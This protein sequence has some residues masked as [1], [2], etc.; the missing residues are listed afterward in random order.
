MAIRVTPGTIDTPDDLPGRRRWSRRRRAA[1]AVAL[2]LLLALVALWFNRRPIADSF[3]RRALADRGVPARYKITDLSFGRQRLTDVVIGDP[4][5]PD[6]VADWAELRTRMTLRG[7]EV[8][9]VRVGRVRLRGRLVDGKVSLGTIDKLMPAPSG[10]PFALPELDAQIG[11]ARMRLETPGGVVG[12]KLTGSGRLD[13][14]FSGNLAAVSD[15]LGIGDACTAGQLRAAVAIRI[16]DARPTIAGPVRAGSLSCGDTRLAGLATRIDLTLGERLDRWQGRAELAAAEVAGA[17]AQVRGVKGRIDFTGSAR[18][19][20]GRAALESGA[21]A[22]AGIGG[23]ALAIDGRY[24][25]GAEQAFQGN[26]QMRGAAL[27]AATLRQVAGLGEAGAGSPVGPL[28]A[29]IA[30][31]GVAAGRRFDAGAE[32]D[33]TNGAKGGRVVV[34]RLS[35]QAASGAQVVLSGAEGVAYGW[36]D[37]RASLNGTLTIGG[38]GLPE[39]AVQLA[40]AQPGGAVTGT[41]IVRP[42]AAGGARLALTPVR[43]TRAGDGTTRFD[44]QATL[45]GPLADGRVDGLVVPL[46]GRWDGGAAVAVNPDCTSVAW[47][48][49]AVS[50]LVLDPA[51]LRLCPTGGALVAVNRAGLGGGARL[52]ATRLAGRLGGTPVTL[53]MRGGRLDLARLDFAL[54]GVESRLGAPERVTRIDAGRLEGRVAGGGVGGRFADAAGQIA[55]VPLLLSGAAGDWR[56]A[57]GVLTLAGGLKLDDTQTGEQRRFETMASDD[58]ALTLAGNTITATG[59]L[60]HPAKQVT[61]ATVAIT[62]E[63]GTGAG[64]A[65]LKVPGIAFG[66]TFQPE[67]LTPL[68]FGVIADVKAVVSGDGHIAWNGQGVTSTGTFR[69]EDAELA[70]AFGPATGISGEVHF[71]DLLGLV[72]APNQ[73]LTI[74]EANPGIPFKDGQLRYRL[75]PEQRI[76]IEGGRW[77]LAGGEMVL[78]PTVLDFSPQKDRRMTFRVTGVDAGLFLQEFE[79]KNLSASGTFDGVL[80]MIFDQRGGRIEGGRLVAREGGGNIAYVGEV[81]KEDVGFWGNLAFQALKSLDYRNLTLEMNGPLAG[82]MIT[83]IRFAGV[84]QGEGTS[85]NFLIRRLARLPLVFNVRIKAPFRQLIDSVQSYY[86]PG[87]LIERNLPALMEAQEQQG[88]APAQ[89]PSAPTGATPP[90]QP[91]ESD[92]RP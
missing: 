21:F 33:A 29:A 44:T 37:G 24:R 27:P 28:M 18:D 36:P 51:R 63:L 61:V 16:A 6:L 8:T 71:T 1:L 64:T 7:P 11:D 79:F 3:V 85:S 92:D 32:L 75:I 73:L 19:T 52:G 81:T 88:G 40:Q 4:R 12:L 70:A 77:P 74:G 41:A 65:D 13:D 80:P 2:V 9:G 58:V 50:S 76:Q 55:N 31:A 48:R 20:Q 15:R 87:R 84:S 43:F 45:S 86:D 60:K 38:G 14:G 25:I 83:A 82:E 59:T 23:E 68:T 30:K 78:E 46:S 67:E 22:A 91:P 54:D 49:L 53:A 39:A 35:A 34:R 69:T 57:G 5:N 89:Q 17:G 72:T 47:Q 10:K 56:F 66:D 62:H 26:A 90:V 42:Y